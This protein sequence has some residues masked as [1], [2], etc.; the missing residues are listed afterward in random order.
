MP[1]ENISGRKCPLSPG[2]RYRTTDHETSVEEAQSGLMRSPGHRRNILNPWHTVV[3]LGI[4]CDDVSCAIVQL[5]DRDYLRYGA[6]PS[7][8]EDGVLTFIAELT[9]GFELSRVQIWYDEPPHALTF[10]QL[11][12]TRSYFLGQ[13]LVASIRPPLEPG[14]RYEEDSFTLSRELP[15]DP[16]RISPDSEPPFRVKREGNIEECVVPPTV[17]TRVQET[18][19][20]VTAEHWDESE[21]TTYLS[22]D[23]GAAMESFGP[24]V[25]TLLV[26][27]DH[28]S[29]ELIPVSEY[30]IFVE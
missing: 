18:V 24:G 2:V 30:S 3:H 21:G 20:W 14:W 12:A 25:Y 19:P 15:Q 13:R 9:D 4:V 22:A 6:L 17:T 28:T 27:A 16:Y 23:I 7:I 26:W 11:G 8:S 29:G 5:F 1:A 10:G